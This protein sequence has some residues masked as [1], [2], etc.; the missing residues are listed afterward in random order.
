MKVA[1]PEVASGSPLEGARVL[2]AP[3]VEPE[4]QNPLARPAARRAPE[5]ASAP[6]SLLVALPPLAMGTAGSTALARLGLPATGRPVWLGVA[7]LGAAA[8][9]LGAVA[10][11]RARSRRPRRLQQVGTVAQLC[12]YPLKSCK[13]VPV[14]EAECTTLG[15]RNGHLQDR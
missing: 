5:P 2:G 11:H 12:I 14:N 10:W 8:V 13:G 1:T 3:E 9:T 15:L 4:S 6:Q 7:A